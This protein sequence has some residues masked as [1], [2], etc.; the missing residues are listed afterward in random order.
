MKA[1]R[2]LMC[3][4]NN[5]IY[6]GFWNVFSPV[7][8][9][10]WGVIP[11]LIFVGTEEELE[12]NNFSTEFGEI[13][14]LDPV[15]EVVTDPSLD[16]SVTWALYYG[17]SLFPD[18]V[19]F[20]TGIDQVL[21]SDR[22]FKWIDSVEDDKYVIGFADAYDNYDLN[23]LGYKSKKE[24]FFFPTS[25]QCGKGKTFQEIFQFEDTWEAEAKK[26]FAKRHEYDVVGRQNLWGLDE[27]Y[28]SDKIAEWEDN[29]KRLVRVR[30]FW[31]DVFPTR[32]ERGG[33]NMSFNPNSL[34]A[35]AYFELHSPR[36]YEQNKEFVDL[37]LKH[38]N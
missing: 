35:G 36:P 30:N 10:K 22:Y 16:W 20:T 32:I 37:V 13:V 24:G 4:N 29:E 2:V 34:K 11:T 12:S 15:P 21:L 17:T 7:W 14:R 1:D 18:D 6:T 26:V 33:K 38:L 23:T 25:H 19:C 9:K 31:S 27:T 5:P 8:K 3:L 28:A